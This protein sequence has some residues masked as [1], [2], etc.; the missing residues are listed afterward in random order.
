MFKRKHG[1]DNDNKNWFYV[2]YDASG[3]IMKSMQGF[4]LAGKI[5]KSSTRGC[6]SCHITAPGG[7]YVFSNDKLTSL[8]EPKMY[9]IRTKKKMKISK[10]VSCNRSC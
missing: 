9:K 8:K 2:Q 3:M 1:Y 10:K 7:D 6:I 4:R 5:A